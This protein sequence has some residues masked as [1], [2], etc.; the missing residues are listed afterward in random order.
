MSDEVKSGDPVLREG[1]PVAGFRRWR[2]DMDSDY[3]TI[4]SN[5]KS[6]LWHPGIN[7]AKCATAP[8]DG[9]PCEHPPTA[10]CSCGIY[11]YYSPQ[12]VSSQDATWPSVALFGTIGSSSTIDGLV[13]AIG[14]DTYFHGKGWRAE[15]VVI[16]AL[17]GE[18]WICRAIAAAY[19]VPLVKRVPDLIRI[20]KE[21]DLRELKTIEGRAA[22]PYSL[23]TPFIPSL[24][25]ADYA[26]LVAGA[27]ARRRTALP[28][29]S[30]PPTGNL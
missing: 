21:H 16:L 7:A 20:S 26:Y 3:P 15:K 30:A 27:N 25:A 11:A 29:R 4:K 17:M 10:D 1:E 12:Q 2:I 23:V 9:N 14:G 8:L 28:D 24:S 19:D 13:A 6:E 18:G 5:V 22:K